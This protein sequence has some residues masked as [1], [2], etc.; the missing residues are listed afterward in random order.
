MPQAKLRQARNF[1]EDEKR[2]SGFS[3][4]QVS[5]MLITPSS[6]ARSPLRPLN[7]LAPTNIS[8]LRVDVYK[9]IPHCASR[10]SI[11]EHTLS[12]ENAVFA[13]DGNKDGDFAQKSTTLPS[14]D[15]PGG[16]SICKRLKS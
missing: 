5:A 10:R 12:A 1:S 11:A 8:P 9:G 4:S 13:I 7:S 14:I 15:N 3:I 16:T 2:N 6:I